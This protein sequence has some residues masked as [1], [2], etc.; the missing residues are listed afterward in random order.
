MGNPEISDVHL[1]KLKS[2][3]DELMYKWKSTNSRKQSD[4]I[5]NESLKGGFFSILGGVV[6][7]L[8]GGPPGAIVGAAVGGSGSALKSAVYSEGNDKAAICNSI[9]YEM[10]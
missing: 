9:D 5:S 6:G 8:L 4:Y 2:N 10:I 7:G 3:I 1:S